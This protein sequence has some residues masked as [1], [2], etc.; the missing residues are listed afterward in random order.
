[1]RIMA[2]MSRPFGP[3]NRE[4]SVALNARLPLKID[5]V[6]R[7]LANEMGRHRVHAVRNS[8]GHRR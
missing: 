6:G 2:C 3:G 7:P 4:I 8:L 1:M 5:G